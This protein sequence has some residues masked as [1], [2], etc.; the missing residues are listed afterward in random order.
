[1]GIVE[2]VVLTDLATSILYFDKNY[3]QLVCDA[4]KHSCFQGGGAAFHLKEVITFHVCAGKIFPP[5]AEM[6]LEYGREP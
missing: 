2:S 5:N 1:V 4:S 3:Y 6:R